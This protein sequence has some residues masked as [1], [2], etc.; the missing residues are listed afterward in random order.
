MTKIN[1]GILIK[2]MRDSAV[3]ELKHGRGYRKIQLKVSPSFIDEYI[4][5]ILAGI[6][7]NIGEISERVYYGK[8]RKTLMENDIIEHFGFV[9][10]DTIETT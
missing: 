1:R 3:I 9:D 7:K 5:Y 8:K 2:K 4:G 6:E 10:N